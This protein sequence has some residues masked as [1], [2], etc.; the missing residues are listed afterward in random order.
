MKNTSTETC[1]GGGK[2][3]TNIKR[4]IENFK[5]I[6]IDKHIKSLFSLKKSLSCFKMFFKMLFLLFLEIKKEEHVLGD[7]ILLFFYKYNNINED[8]IEKQVLFLKTGLILKKIY[9]G[10]MEVIL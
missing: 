8:C 6:N 5:K 10:S 7:I 4:N 2:N 1:K 3:T 9:N